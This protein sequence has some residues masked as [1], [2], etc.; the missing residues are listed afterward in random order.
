MKSLV[1]VADDPLTIRSNRFA[2]R[3]AAGFRVIATIDGRS[4]ARAELAR[5]SPDVVLVND[6]CQRT[7]V[8]ARIREAS[9]ASPDAKVVLLSGRMDGPWFDDAFTAGADA[10]IAR[11]LRPSALGLLLEQVVDGNIIHAPRVRSVPEEPAR[12]ARLVPLARQ[13]ASAARTSA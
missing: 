3:H 4:S 1:V 11:T 7:N 8:L 10:V 9:E 5:L 12:V 6:M 13:D 2:L